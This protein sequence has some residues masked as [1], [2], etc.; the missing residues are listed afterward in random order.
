MALM[1]TISTIEMFLFHWSSN[2]IN[3]GRTNEEK[4]RMTHRMRRLVFARE[5]GTNDIDGCCSEFR[6]TFHLR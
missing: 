5:V 4:K 6:R 3:E 1:W 2:V